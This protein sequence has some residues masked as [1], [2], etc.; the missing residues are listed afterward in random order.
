M[1]YGEE[2]LNPNAQVADQRMTKTGNEYLGFLKL[3]ESL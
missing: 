1:N 2:L 3:D